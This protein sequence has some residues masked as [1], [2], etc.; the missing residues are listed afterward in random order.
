MG[1]VIGRNEKGKFK[2]ICTWNIGETPIVGDRIY[3]LSASKRKDEGWY[4]VV[5]RVWKLVPQSNDKPIPYVSDTV[6]G[7][8]QIIVEKTDD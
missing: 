8:L 7:H 2:P 1:H 3:L 6:G 4:A 5:D